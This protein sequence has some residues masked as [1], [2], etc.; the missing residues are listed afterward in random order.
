MIIRPKLLCLDTS[1]WS[2]LAR[3]SAT[4]PYAQNVLSALGTG[5][6]VPFFTSSHLEEL[7]QHENDEEFEKRLSLLRSLPFVGFFKI[8][9]QIE[10]VG[11][12]IEV[13]EFEMRA[14][15]ERSATNHA[16]VVELVQPEVT[17]GFCSGN[18][19]H[20]IHSQA[21]STYRKY[22]AKTRLTDA[23]RN[24]SL[25]HFPLPG[26]N[27]DEKLP[28]N[29]R[30]LRMRT[31]QEAGNYFG[32]QISWLARK[33]QSDGDLRA[34]SSDSSSQ[35][36]QHFLRET[37]EQ[38]LPLFDMEGDPLENHLKIFGVQRERLPAKPTYG[39][40]GY[41]AVFMKQIELHED[42][43]SLP[44]G[45]LARLIRKESLPSW[46]VWQEVDRAM[47]RLQKAE[48]SSLN[49]KWMVPF[50]LYVDAMEVDKR[51]LDCVKQAAARHPLLKQ[52]QSRLF[53]SR[54]LKDLSEKIDALT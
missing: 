11:N 24:A 23:A 52:V 16:Q 31:K 40:V 45:T 22:F 20:S 41:E 9:S 46:V 14:V 53:R 44:R 38:S 28:M 51:V 32:K 25:S 1:S 49:D 48:A 13:R 26:Y 7:A 6:L 8:C 50:S 36:A 21:L 39:D 42:R 19:F 29:S 12:P 47:K 15:V 17:N 34:D 30:G 35:I 4:S 54:D 2:R 33:L 27:P 10:Q 5:R 18:E 3:E 37:F 43:L